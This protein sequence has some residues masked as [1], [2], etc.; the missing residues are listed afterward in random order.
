MEEDIILQENQ[1]QLHFY[2]NNDEN[3][4]NVTVQYHRCVLTAQ[5]LAFSEKLTANSVAVVPI[6]LIR[7]IREIGNR[8]EMNIDQ[9]GKV[10]I[11]FP[12]S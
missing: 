11:S 1:V 8:L 5:N 10:G 7:D 4:K 12:Q 2:D 6:E 9:F 3:D